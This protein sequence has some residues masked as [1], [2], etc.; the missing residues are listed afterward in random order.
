M[1]ELTVHRDNGNPPAQPSQKAAE[2]DP[3]GF[4]RSMLRWDPFRAMAPVFA[5]EGLGFVP[6]FE[7]KET[8]DAYLVRAD[9]PGVKEQDL[10]VST[11]GH[12]LTVRG[13]REAERKD[14]R[15][16]YYLYERSYGSFARTLSL[17]EGADPGQVHAALADGVLTITVGKRA[18]LQPKKIAVQ[19]PQTP[20]S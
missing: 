16:T 17:P 4:V 5:D 12:R 6:A 14:E 13:K 9:L 20:R 7:V 18:E 11:T 10:D 3:I 2:L 15:D 1:A 8:K 19:T